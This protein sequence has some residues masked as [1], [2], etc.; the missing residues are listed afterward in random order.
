MD[1][2]EAMI[3]AAGNDGLHDRLAAAAVAMHKE[4][5]LDTIQVFATVM[6]PEGGTLYMAMGAGNWFARVGQARAF[7]QREDGKEFR[8]ET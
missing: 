7:V 1:E 8:G 3:D 5:G 2:M 4:M 6:K